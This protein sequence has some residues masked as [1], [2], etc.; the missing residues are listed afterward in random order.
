MLTVLVLTVLVSEWCGE[1]F[2]EDF[3]VLVQAFR[4][5]RSVFRQISVSNLFDVF[6]ATSNG[7][8]EMLFLN[9]T[10]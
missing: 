2:R 4:G 10:S 8:S 9:E 1:R 3:T 5:S 6:R 7:A